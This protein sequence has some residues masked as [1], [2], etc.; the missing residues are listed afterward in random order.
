MF[1]FFMTADE[2]SGLYLL[3]QVRPEYFV[4][5]LKGLAVRLSWFLRKRK[6]ASQTIFDTV[7]SA[8]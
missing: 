2:L 3:N 6:I 8:L 1:L 4:I 5:K 7:I